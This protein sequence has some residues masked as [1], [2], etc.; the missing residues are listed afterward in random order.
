MITVLVVEDDNV[1]FGQIKQVLVSSGVSEERISHANNSVDAFEMCRR[2]RY[3]ILLLD[4]NLPK[5][6]DGAA[7]R[8]EG[9]AL[10]R[11]IGRDPECLKP[12]YVVGITAYD[13]V[14][15]EFGEEFADQLWSLVHYSEQSDRWKGQVRGKVE[16]V[17]AL[18]RSDN[19]SDGTTYGVDVAVI[20]ALS[21][22]E[23]AAVKSLPC[24]WQPLRVAH[25]HT[26]YIV[27][28]IET[29]TRPISIISAA[30][31]RMGMPASAVLASK[32]VST[33]RP[34][35][36][37]MTGICAG[38][39]S[40]TKL[41]DVV[42]ANPAFDWGSGKIDSKDGRP[43]F[44]PS[45]HQLEMNTDLHGILAEVFSDPSLL[46]RI[47]AECPPAPERGNLEVHFAP[48]ASGAAVV[49]NA[50]IFDELLDNNR[51]IT[52]LEMEAYGIHV[53][54]VGCAK[55]RPLPLVMKGVCD[56]A[57]EDKSDDYQS[58]SAHVSAR[59]FYEAVRAL[60]TSNRIDEI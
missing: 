49:A 30:A 52:G 16:Y 27:G 57:D 38:R 15:T 33:F 35:I 34:R 14:V 6:Y 4:I 9:I 24:D 25:D 19:F 20:C 41:G 43:R 45:P 31:P 21:D 55:P 46:A 44:R 7:A 5:R 40:K 22:P 23:W 51:D 11:R 28:T 36:L 10:L 2:S 13:D 37:G 47:R 54:A 17:S 29:S 1:K 48:I 8:G 42:V 12:R 3:D 56:Y 18:R 39:S 53:A 60:Y 59:C 26:R 32:M 58:F 50:G